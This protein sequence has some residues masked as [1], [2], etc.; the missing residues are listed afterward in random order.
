[1]LLQSQNA[2]TFSSDNKPEKS[3]GGGM[4]GKL[5]ALGVL[6]GLGLYFANQSQG[7]EAEQTSGNGNSSA[8]EQK[9]AAEAPVS[10][11]EAPNNMKDVLIANADA[12]EDGTMQEVRVGD[13]PKDKVLVVRYK[14]NLHAIGAYC[15]H[16]G[17]PLVNGVMFDDKVLCPWHAAGFSVMTGAIELNPGI[18]GVPKYEIIN[19]D[20][21]QYVRVPK[22]L[23]Q[24]QVAPMAKRDPSNKTRMLIIGGGAAGLNCAETLRQS[25]FTGEIMVLSNEKR[26]PYDR[27]LLSKGLGAAK[28]DNLLMRSAEF[29]D[30]YNID[31]QLGYSV[32]SINRER[33]TV[34]LDT[35]AE[36][37]YDKLL[38]ATGGRARV[39][40]TPGIELNNVHVLRSGEDQTAIKEAAAKAK[41][42][43]VVGGGFIS[44]ECTANLTKMYNGKKTIRMICD[45]QVPLEPQFG[46][47]V[48]G[49][50]LNEHEKN[51]ALVY[52]GR[53]VFKLK[54]KGDK[55]GNV[56]TVVMDNGYEL[57]ADLVIVGAGAIPNTELAK[58]AGL[59][60][61]VNGG[62]KLNPFLQSSD[63]DIF[64]A[65]DIASFPLWHTGTQARI[66]HWITA[67][68]QGSHAA[69][70]MLGKMV[71]YGN[72]PFF[73]TNHYQKG[74]QYVGYA[75]EYD[76]VHIDGEPR[77][78]KFLAYYI[79]DN[80]IL[81]ASGQGRSK[82]L[83]T[84]FEA[85][86]QAKLPPA[87]AIKSGEE[88]PATIFTKL[89]LNKGAGACR[90]ANCC[91]KKSIVQ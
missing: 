24:K 25:N 1:M 32:K 65:G 79:K 43:V 13:G 39:P 4:T 61:D 67:Q 62:V 16:F 59:E 42:I 3:S 57:P 77:S 15:S 2:R 21:K 34:T 51:G 23:E 88:T 12:I 10:F 33:K 14:G 11:V 66:E 81:A 8:A 73:W 56:T 9:P 75:R 48:G 46:R 31:Y 47:D 80:K 64:A 28:V 76:E 5:V 82:D 91:Q 83:L 41:N 89:Q 86:Q 69:F 27:T 68:D 71:P 29:L 22:K 45:F 38:L 58:E 78:N 87:S 40:N 35:G 20:G 36:I 72:I 70:N 6:G 52:A 17:A 90:R 60:M 74:M 85:M 30:N 7:E 55:N 49:M 44:S 53:N 26:L 18:D 50:L 84:I 19:N 63:N 37:A 54:Y